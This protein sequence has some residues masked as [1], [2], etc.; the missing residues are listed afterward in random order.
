M[1]HAFRFMILVPGTLQA[2]LGGGFALLH[3]PFITP[4]RLILNTGSLSLILIGSIFTSVA[5]SMLAMFGVALV[6]GT[7]YGAMGLWWSLRFPIKA[8]R[9]RSLSSRRGSLTGLPA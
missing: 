3:F 7:L 4:T 2:L 6:L 9:M 8:A 1:N 5:A